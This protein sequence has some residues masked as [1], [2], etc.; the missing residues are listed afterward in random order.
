MLN[1]K[2]EAMW[3][4]IQKF[5]EARSSIGADFDHTGA[6]SPADKFFTETDIGKEGKV[7]KSTLAETIKGSIAD[8]IGGVTQ[9]FNWSRQDRYEDWN[10]EPKWVGK[11]DSRGK[12]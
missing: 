8:A 5:D 1:K 10:K 4:V 2:K 3:R 11:N 12:W 7:W 9:W 6:K